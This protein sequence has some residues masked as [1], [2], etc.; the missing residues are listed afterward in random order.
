MHTPD[1]SRR[2]LLG[3]AAAGVAG[4]ALGACGNNDD[5]ETAST[6]TSA[7]PAAAPVK[8][9]GGLEITTAVY[10]KNH[11]SAPL[12]WQQFAPPGLKVKPVVVT[13]PAD[14]SRSLAAGTLDF[15]LMGY[16]NT[17]IEASTTGMVSKMI[18]MCSRQGSGIVARKDRG[19]SAVSDLKGKKMGVPPPGVQVMMLTAL[20]EKSGLKLGTDVQVVPLAFADHKAALERGDIDAYAGTEPIPTQSVSEGVGVR[21]PGLYDTPAGDFNTAMW[22]APKHH[23]NPDLLR[24]VAKMQRDSAELLTPGGTNSE[25]EWRKLLVDQFG[26]TEAVY[27]EALNNVGAVWRFDDGRRKQ[28]EGAAELMLAQGVIKTKPN[29]DELLL[30]DFQ[31]TS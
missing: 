15:G 6:S 27:K 20:L 26:F 16:Y 31:P 7:G 11:G 8:D 13:S 19:I 14:I 9:F 1:L 28:Y 24:A 5:E 10:A 17:I 12:Y 23:T 25:V 18:C 29:I 3:L 21:I 30:L 22:A 2:K 4:L